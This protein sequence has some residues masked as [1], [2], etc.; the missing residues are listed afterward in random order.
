MISRVVKK[1]FGFRKNKA[2][3]DA[4]L[5][6]RVAEEL[7]KGNTYMVAMGADRATIEHVFSN[8]LELKIACASE[9]FEMV[10]DTAKSLGYTIDNDE[11][12]T[13]KKLILASY[14]KADDKSEL[15]ELMG[16]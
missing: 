12:Y 7:K 10:H 1:M 4:N 15:I 6:E 13:D 11:F 3:F 8:Q 16:R 14:K 2:K 9:K 5:A